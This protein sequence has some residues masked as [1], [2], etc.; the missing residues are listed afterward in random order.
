MTPGTFFYQSKVAGICQMRSGLEVRI[1]RILD[2]LCSMHIYKSWSYE[3][4]SFKYKNHKGYFHKY[5]PDFRIIDDMGKVFFIEGKGFIKKND[6]HKL[7]AMKTL[8]YQVYLLA[9]SDVKQWEKSLKI[10]RT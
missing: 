3:K 8:G 4:F 7:E 9:D 1:A 10:K 2:Y 5:I 6:F